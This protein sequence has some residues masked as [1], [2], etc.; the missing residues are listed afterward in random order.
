M[1]RNTAHSASI[2][3][4]RTA[5]RL[6]DVVSFVEKAATTCGL[7]DRD[8]QSMTLAAEEIFIYLCQHAGPEEAVEISCSPCAYSLRLDF[9]FA[10]SA[11]DFRAFNLT[12]KTDFT[13]EEDVRAMGLVLASRSVDRLGITRAPQNMLCLTLVKEK[14]YAPV[15]AFPDLT[16]GEVAECSLR[17]ADPEQ[18]ELFALM[19]ARHI[20]QERLPPFFLFPGKLRDMAASGEYGCAVAV[21]PHGRQAGGVFWRRGEGKTLECFGPYQF[22]GCDERDLRTALLDACLMDLSKTS[23]VGLLN[24]YPGGRL[25]ERDFD[26]LG[27]YST[28]TGDGGA[29]AEVV[30]FRQLREAPSAKSWAAPALED[31]LLQ[32][33]RRLVL[34]RDVEFVTPDD[35][36]Q[37]AGPAERSEKWEYSAL[38]TRFQRERNLATL[39]PLW[40]GRDIEENVARHVRLLGEENW[41]NISAEIDLGLPWQAAFTDALLKHGFTPRIVLPHAGQGDVVLFR[42]PD[43]LNALVP[44]FVKSFEPYIPSQP[45]DVLQQKYKYGALHRLN[46]NENALGPPPAAQQALA[47]FPPAD[48]AIYPSGDSY[49]LRLKLAEHCGLHPDQFIVTNGAN[50]SITLL[51]KSFCES[52]D[53]IVTADRTYGGYEWVARFSGV[54]ARLT[55]LKD[56]GFDTDALLAARDARTKIYFICNPNNPTGTFWDETLLIRFLE[57][58]GQRSIV[59]LDEAY[60]EFVDTPGYPNGAAL[61][62]RFPNLVVLRTFSK[63]YGLSGLRIRY[64]AGDMDVV[65][66]IRR[67]AIVYSVNTVAQTAALAALGDEEHILRTRE[68]VACGKEFLLHR[69][70]PLGLDLMY[71]EGNYLS[72]KLPFSDSLAYRMMMRQGVMVRMMTPFRFPNSIRITIGREDSMLACADALEN[73]M[74]VGAGF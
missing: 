16:P 51:I 64:L 68:M 70:C 38:T 59:V 31:F 65:N 40:P 56:M 3:T 19:A 44:D 72:A 57:H 43:A 8:A 17:S 1:A 33:Y 22:A 42:R 49:H 29:E 28:Y 55:A 26:E 30:Y 15:S 67:T 18:V 45:G 69:L 47:N 14:S 12:H 9:L 35:Y 2:R 4:L 7:A 27:A 32:E 48:A 41:R 21:D 6:P 53:N 63:M 58:V 66:M 73:V 60:F 71:G 74:D 46:N 23:A 5:E 54:D 25:S 10:E 34:P 20:G 52:G 50:E 39:L 62:S 11:F 13:V 24:H 37:G 36:P 61:I